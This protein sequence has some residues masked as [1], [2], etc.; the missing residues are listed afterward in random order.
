L[1]RCEHFAHTT[2]VTDRLRNP[3]PK[4]EEGGVTAGEQ[5]DGTSRLRLADGSAGESSV[6]YDARLYYE[7]WAF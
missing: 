5:F 3:A 4:W 6:Y 2:S 7:Y 1:R